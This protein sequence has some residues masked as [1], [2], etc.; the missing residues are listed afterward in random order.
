MNA[1]VST[2][3][4]PLIDKYSQL[5]SGFEPHWYVHYYEIAVNANQVIPKF[6]LNIDTDADF[7]WR[8][9]KGSMDFQFQLLFYDPYNNQLASGLDMA[10]NILS[11]P[12][13]GLMWPEVAC[14][15]GSVIQVDITEYTG[16]SGTLKLALMGIKIY[17]S[18][19]Q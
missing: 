1:F 2:P 6:P 12:Q 9:L 3:Y 8:G 4:T 10:E 11:I 5:P 13:P 7:M 14:P 17:R 16:N 19:N 15:R 18:V